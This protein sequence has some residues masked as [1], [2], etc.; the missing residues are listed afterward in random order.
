MD[1]I[2]I[3]MGEGPIDAYFISSIL[4]YFNEINY[5][6]IKNHYKFMIIDDNKKLLNNKRGI[7]TIHDY[8]TKEYIYYKIKNTYKLLVYGDNGKDTIIDNVLPTFFKI[9]GNTPEPINMKILSIL[10]EDGVSS[11]I[12]LNK[13]H[14]KLNARGLNIEEEFNIQSHN[15]Y[16]LIQIKEDIRHSVEIFVFQIPDSLEKQLVRKSIDKFNISKNEANKL[17]SKD[18]HDSLKI[19]RERKN[20]E[21]EEF[22]KKVISENWFEGE[23]WYKDLIN[24]IQTD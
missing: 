21:V 5:D 14:E 16:I 18:P 15:G 9:I 2:R 12:V 7:N 11:E 13:I 22:V 3:Y 24:F 6:E 10:D 8:L 4:D 19:I 20:L 1:T 23:E 17:L